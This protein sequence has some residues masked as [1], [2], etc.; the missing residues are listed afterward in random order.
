MKHIIWVSVTE[1]LKLSPKAYFL[2]IFVS[3]KTNEAKAFGFSTLISHNFH[4]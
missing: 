2:G 3:F 1:F 4:T